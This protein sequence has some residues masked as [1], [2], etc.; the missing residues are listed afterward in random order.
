MSVSTIIEMMKAKSGL[1]M[2]A[3]NKR[4]GLKSPSHIWKL[5]GGDRKPNDETVKKIIKFAEEIGMKVTRDMIY[6]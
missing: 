3:L 5:I 6:D 2:Y 4:I 1:S